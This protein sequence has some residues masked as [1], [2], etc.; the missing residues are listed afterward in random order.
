MNLKNFQKNILLAPYTTFKIGGPAKY[1]FIAK[2]SRQIIEAIKLAKKLSISYFVL[3]GGSNILVNDKGFN[4]LVI[5]VK[6]EKYKIQD[7]IV[8]SEAGVLLS[9]LAKSSINKN[10][11][12]LEWAAGVPGTLGGAIRGNSGAFGHSISELVKNVSVFSSDNLEVNNYNKKQCKFFYR[13]SIF[14]NNKG[15][16]PVLSVLARKSKNEIFPFPRSLDNKNIILSAQLNL[17]KGDSKKS[18][19]II[20]EYLKTRK[21]G[22]PNYPSAGSVFKNLEVKDLN[23]NIIKNYPRINE[24]IKGGKIP[25]AY[26]I[27]A[28]DL[29]GKRIG[30][31]EIYQK[32]A[33]FIINLGNATAEQIVILISLIKQKVRNKFGIQLEEEIE[34]VGF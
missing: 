2:S 3:G 21:K 27:E 23:L 33:N 11:S 15:F 19:E 20:K 8:I 24:V 18:G 32:H 10:L 34:Y 22:N 28:C 29:K 17:K 31:A 9:S 6:N 5:K 1:F 13:E 7:K 4:G 16:H 14:K 26:F 25:A 12:G 30:D